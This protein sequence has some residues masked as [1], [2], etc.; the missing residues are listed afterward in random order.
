MAIKKSTLTKDDKKFIERFTC[1]DT[2]C[3]EHF[4]FITTDRDLNRTDKNAKIF[5]GVC[6]KCNKRIELTTNQFKRWQR[7]FTNVGVRK[8]VH[9]IDK[10]FTEE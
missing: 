10:L 8:V 3:D 4:D 9:Q 5:T 6:K 2:D 1:Y 7:I